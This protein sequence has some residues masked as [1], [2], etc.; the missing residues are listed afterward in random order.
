MGKARRRPRPAPLWEGD[1]DT[2]VPPYGD[3]GDPLHETLRAVGKSLRNDGALD[4]Q[5]ASS[6]L[7][8][9]SKEWRVMAYY[10][11]GRRQSAR[12]NGAPDDVMVPLQACAVLL[13]RAGE[14]SGAECP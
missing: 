1:G 2:G 10:Q 11:G 9:G 14:W 13:K 7:P 6:D 4:V 12:A 3:P 5:W 8:D